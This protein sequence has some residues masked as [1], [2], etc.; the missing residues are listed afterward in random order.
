MGREEINRAK[1]CSVAGLQ[2][3]LRR[4]IS[5]PD[6][7]PLAATNRL[8]VSEDV[9]LRDERTFKDVIHKMSHS[10]ALNLKKKLKLS[11]SRRVHSNRHKKRLHLTATELAIHF[12]QCKSLVRQKLAAK[13]VKTE[14]N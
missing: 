9:A 1:K 5:L 2:V 4:Y 3:N 10:I 13:V 14:L 7:F 6:L 11:L 12:G 8:W